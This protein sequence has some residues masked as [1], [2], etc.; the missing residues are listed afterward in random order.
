VP[1]YALRVPLLMMAGN[2]RPAHP[3]PPRT[4]GA[5]R[6]RLRTIRTATPRIALLGL[7]HAVQ[8]QAVGWRRRLTAP[9]RLVSELL[10]QQTLNNIYGWKDCHN[11]A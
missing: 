4:T 9:T 5:R 3:V 8:A 2:S 10:P 1:V 6:I 7:P 11:I